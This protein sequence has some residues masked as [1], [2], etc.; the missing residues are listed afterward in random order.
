M[1]RA[2]SH[3]V[4]GAIYQP[5]DADDKAM[6]SHILSCLDTVTRDHPLAKVVLLGDFNQMRDAALLSYPLRQVVRSP[7]RENAILDKIYTNLQD[8]Y[9]RPVVLP[10]IGTSDHRAVVMVPTFQDKLER[11]KE[12]GEDITMVGT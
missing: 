9:E 10:N 7:T 6:T 5:P 1:P 4:V 11:A 12:R 2:L 3:V 8:W